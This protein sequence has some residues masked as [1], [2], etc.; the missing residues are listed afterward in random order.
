MTA[1]ML[2]ARN[3]IAGYAPGMPIV[4]DVSI[5]VA[6]GEIVTIIGPNG[7]GKSTFLKAIAGLVLFEG[8]TVH[9]DDRDV[10]GLSAH[11]MARVGVGF[12]P[13]TGNIFTNLTIHENLVAGGHTLAPAELRRRLARAYNVSPFLAERRASLGRVL[14]G[15]QRQML[16]VARALMTDPKLVM[17]D[18]PTAGLAPKIVGEV[19]ADLRRLAE[20]G[21]AVL[22]VEQNAKAALRISD[23]GYVLAEGRN[24]MSGAAQDL[25]NDAAVGEAFLGGRRVAS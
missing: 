9:Y 19:F 12:V 15:G 5:D 2:V 13:Q 11:E 14:S 8:G 22:M 17:L 6:P 3:V 25:L 16:A 21:V 24:R 20:A 18:E 4:H 1:P 23:R 10:S 7:A